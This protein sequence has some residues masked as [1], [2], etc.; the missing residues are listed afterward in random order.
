MVKNLRNITFTLKN[1]M[2]FMFN[3]IVLNTFYT[4]IVLV[5]NLF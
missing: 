2:L 4:Q 3:E 1:K 5:V